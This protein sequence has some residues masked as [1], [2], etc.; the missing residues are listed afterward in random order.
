MDHDLNC[1]RNIYN[2]VKGN[3]EFKL[4]SDEYPFYLKHLEWIEMANAE[5]QLF[6]FSHAAL[7][8]LS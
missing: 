6:K 2:R 3:D 8:L 1:L 7:K 5:L 4:E